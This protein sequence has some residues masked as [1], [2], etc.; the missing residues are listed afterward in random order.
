M[1][2]RTEAR[3]EAI[4]REAAQLFMEMGYE[5]A[6]MG[7]LTTRLGGSKATLYGYFRSKEELFAAVVE[8]L[9]EAH[10]ADAVAELQQLATVGLERGLAR[11]A[12]KML[13]LILRE[14][15]LALHRMVVGESGRS[16]IGEAF[17]ELGPRRCMQAVAT[18]FDAAMARGDMARG[19]ADLLA[20]QFLGLVKSETEF[21]MYRRQLPR[22][23]GKEI[24]AMA[25]R[26][27]QVF[28]GGYAALGDA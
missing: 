10:L 17:V 21:L 15:A 1:K 23:A 8:G 24:K 27:V 4:V 9:G 5:R 22:L 12:E 11:F 2:V 26:A 16:S 14:D 18:A 7:E 20:M 13:T 19:P 25:Q 28:V 6:T 3:R